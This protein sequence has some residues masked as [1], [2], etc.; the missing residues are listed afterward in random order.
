MVPAPSKADELA[1]EGPGSNSAHAGASREIPS[2]SRCRALDRS[3]QQHKSRTDTRRMRSKFRIRPCCLCRWGPRAQP[4]CGTAVNPSPARIE[5]FSV[6]NGQGLAAPQLTP[7]DSPNS[8][9]RSRG[10][11]WP[12]G[13]AR[14][15]WP[16]PTV[17]HSCALSVQVR[18]SRREAVRVRAGVVK[19]QLEYA[20]CPC[21][22]GT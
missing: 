4:P 17:P 15:R 2:P 20:A 16:C 3:R 14:L 22:G 11:L 12:I 8:G 10:R 1:L 5:C 9:A 7:T 13:P 6:A 21:P 18:G 19:A